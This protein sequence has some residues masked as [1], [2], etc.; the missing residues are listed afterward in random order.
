M[1][2][3]WVD[4]GN[5]FLVPLTPINADLMGAIGKIEATEGYQQNV[6]NCIREALKVIK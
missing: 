5:N 6:V 1:I 3:E 4:Q 2:R